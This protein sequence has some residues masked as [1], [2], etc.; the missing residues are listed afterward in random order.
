[1]AAWGATGL[2]GA[3]LAMLTAPADRRAGRWRSCARVV[4]FALRRVPGRRRLGDL[5]RS[6]RRPA[7]RVRRQGARVRLVHAAGCLLFALAFG[8]ALTARSRASRAGSRSRGEPPGWRGR[9]RLRRSALGARALRSPGLAG[10]SARAA[11]RAAQRRRT[12]GY[13]LAAQNA[14]RRLRGRARASPPQ[15]LYSGWAALGLAA[16][17]REPAGR[18]PRRAQPDRLHRAGGGSALG[19]G[20]L[21]RTILSLRAAGLLGE[22]SAG[23]TWSPRS[24]ADIAPDGSVAE[25]VNLTAF[26]VLALRGAGVAPPAR[27]VAGWRAS[28][29]RDGGFNFATPAARATSTTP[30]RR[31]RRWPAPAARPASRARGRLHP[32]PAEPRRRLPVQPGEARMRSRR[33]GRSRG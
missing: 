23:T 8:P 25:Q 22:R 32:R 33:P 24:R 2:I 17:G 16:A 5:Q 29:T 7:R 6:Q 21:E 13:L 1:M 11:A 20:S 12:A 31:S 4:G 28:R 15:Q 26:A 18:Q 14:R 9:G 10:R 3:G 19:P 27:T 30:G